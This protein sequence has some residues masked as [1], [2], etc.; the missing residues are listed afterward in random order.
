VKK[1]IIT[2]IILQGVLMSAT[3]EQL[4]VRGKSVPFIF[5]EDKNLPINLCD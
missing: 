5:E 3:L 2:L 4:R 1:I